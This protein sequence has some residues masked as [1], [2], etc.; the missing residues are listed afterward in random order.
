MISPPSSI[1]QLKPVNNKLNA[2]NGGALRNSKAFHKI[3]ASISQ[4]NFNGLKNVK[5][6]KMNGHI[7]R[8]NSQDSNR[9]E[10][11][12]KQ[13]KKKS[14]IVQ[15]DYCETNPI[16]KSMEFKKESNL[17]ST[18]SL[19]TIGQLSNVAQQENNAQL[20]NLME[21]PIKERYSSVGSQGKEN[22]VNNKKT[23]S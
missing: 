16:M 2:A 10:K 7:T 17:P 8:G 19:P 22:T 20:A 15:I 21:A 3:A 11:S 13:K 14:K 1:Q 4:P 18:M 9:K 12:P 6:G 23:Y 5:S